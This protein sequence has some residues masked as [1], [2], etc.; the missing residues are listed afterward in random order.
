MGGSAS[1]TSEAADVAASSG[2]HA[3]T[4]AIVPS[5]PAACRRRRRCR[6]DVRRTRPASGATARAPP[7][8]ASHDRT[9]PRAGG[10]HRG[11]HRIRAAAVTPPIT[12]H[13]R[14]TEPDRAQRGTD[15]DDQRT[16]G[17]ARVGEQPPDAEELGALARWGGVGPQ[18]HDHARADAVPEPEQHR[19]RGDRGHG[20]R[21]RQQQ[22]REPHDEH[23][24]DGDP[25]PALAGPSPCRP[26]RTAACRC[27][28]RCRTRRS[29]SSPPDRGAR[30]TAG[31]TVMR[32]PR[33]APTSITATPSVANSCRCVRA[34]SS[35]PVGRAPRT[36]GRVSGQSPRRPRG[37]PP[38]WSPRPASRSRPCDPVT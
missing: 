36:R 30:P 17:I 5:S 13:R 29:W 25:Q 19:D 10:I 15:R 1:A 3:L 16:A 26:G 6:R 11:T 21:Q 7:R 4:R 20:G 33:I 35:N 28:R 37:P 9:E 2:D 23:R 32:A 14:D 34:T 18:R 31:T 24:R 22:H 38:R 8:R 12:S 27:R